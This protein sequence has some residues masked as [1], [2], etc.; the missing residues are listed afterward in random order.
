M[1]KEIFNLNNLSKEE[2]EA[3]V[4]AVEKVRKENFDKEQRQLA[5]EILNEAFK[6][7]V[8]L[9]GE[10]TAKHLLRE[11][12]YELRNKDRIDKS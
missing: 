8:I 7:M 4:K 11:K 1:A 5:K 3:A 6:R 10:P 9:V 2:I 12:N